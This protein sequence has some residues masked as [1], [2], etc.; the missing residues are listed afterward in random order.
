MTPF[1]PWRIAGDEVAR[2]NGTDEE[3]LGKYGTPNAVPIVF[4]EFYECVDCL[5]EGRSLRIIKLE[6]LFREDNFR[7]F[8]GVIV[9]IDEFSEP[10]K[11]FKE[12]GML[13]DRAW[14]A[15]E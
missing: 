12:P 7:Y 5:A 1:H 15:E 2:R 11:N 14:N 6:F 3:T 8:V 13:D 4:V 9:G 10:L